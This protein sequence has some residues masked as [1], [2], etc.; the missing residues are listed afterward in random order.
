MTWPKGAGGG[1]YG[2]TGGN[3]GFVGLLDLISHRVL[4]RSIRKLSVCVGGR[5]GRGR[6]KKKMKEAGLWWSRIPWALGLCGSVAK[7]HLRFSTELAGV[8]RVKVQR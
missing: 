6:E 3:A 7:Y 5:M 8:V 4:Y 1:Q 2:P